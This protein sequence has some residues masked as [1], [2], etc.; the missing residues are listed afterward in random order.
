MK[1]DQS[2][3]NLYVRIRLSPSTSLHGLVR[4]VVVGSYDRR[5]GWYDL[6]LS[7]FPYK[8]LRYHE[9]GI[10]KARLQRNSG[11]V[12]KLQRCTGRSGS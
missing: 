9:R 3:N 7:S 10:R 5:L 4:K 12:R 2:T 1:I 11:R 6:E 8:T